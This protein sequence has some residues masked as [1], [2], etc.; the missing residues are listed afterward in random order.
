MIERTNRNLLAKWAKSGAKLRGGLVCLV[1]ILS[2]AVFAACQA[3][4]PNVLP[5]P[6]GPVTRVTLAPG[7]VIKLTFSGAPEMNQTQKIQADGKLSLPL[8]GEVRAGGKSLGQLQNELVGSYKEQLK[9]S[10]VVVS[11][12]S[13]VTNVFISGAVNKPG[14][15][16]FDRPTTVL[17]AVMEAGGPNQ[18]GNLRR[19]HLVRLANGVQRTMLLDLGSTLNGQT[20][21]ASYVRDGDIVSVPE[22]AF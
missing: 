11:L 12:E 2:V 22:S 10:D 6:A 7:D 17:Q 19:V 15:I 5:P 9:N 3:P 4:A 21:R 13:A 8:L 18:Y 16:A 14:K 1:L 20:T